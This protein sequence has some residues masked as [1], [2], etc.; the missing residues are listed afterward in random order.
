MNNA[1]PTHHSKP[2]AGDLSPHHPPK[3]QHRCLTISYLQNYDSSGNKQKLPNHL[4]KI[5]H[6]FCIQTIIKFQHLNGPKQPTRH[7]LQSVFGQQSSRV[8]TTITPKIYLRI[9]R[10]STHWKGMTKLYLIITMNTTNYPRK[11]PRN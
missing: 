6:K 4:H 5:P 11:I 1:A 3:L 9:E 2:V 8:Q 7:T 10:I